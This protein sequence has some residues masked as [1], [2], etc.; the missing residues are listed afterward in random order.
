MRTVCS[1]QKINKVDSGDRIHWIQ[2]PAA[3]IVYLPS[4]LITARINTRCAPAS[5]QK[6]RPFCVLA[7]RHVGV[8]AT[9][10]VRG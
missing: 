4:A 8:K 7:V 1:L 5:V 2:S 3:H 10:L 6:Q 9:G